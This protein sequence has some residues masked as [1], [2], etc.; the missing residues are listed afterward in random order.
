[1][2]C[3]V[4]KPGRIRRGDRIEMEEKARAPHLGDDDSIFRVY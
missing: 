4:V 2:L 1:L 3:R